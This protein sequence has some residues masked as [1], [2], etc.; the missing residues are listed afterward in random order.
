[1]RKKMLS[2][3]LSKVLIYVGTKLFTWVFKKIALW[4]AVKRYERKTQEAID[5]ANETGNTS[6]LENFPG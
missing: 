6:D 3:I 1:M 4:I 2:K 5:H